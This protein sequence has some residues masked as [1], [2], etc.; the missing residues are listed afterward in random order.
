MNKKLVYTLLL[1]LTAMIW[2]AAF[3]AQSVSMELVEPFTFSA[4]RFAMGALALLPVIRVMDL[5]Q[6]RGKRALLPLR[7]DRELRRS[8]LV[9]GVIICAASN[10][11][12][13]G[14]QFTT[15]GKCGFI[16]TL[17]VAMVPV[18]SVLLLKRRYG[19]STWLGVGMAVVGMYFLCITESFAVTKGDVLVLL[20]AVLFAGHILAV[21]HYIA[22]VDGVRLAC[23]Q[24]LVNAL[25]SG[26]LMFL[27]EQPSLSAILAAWKPICYAGLLSCAV[28][29]TLQVVCQKEVEPT[30]A[31]LI[32][33]LESV[34]S[35][36]F[37]WLLL[38]EQLSRRE[39]L[40][41]VLTFCAVLIVELAPGIQRRKQ[42]TT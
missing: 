12:Q 27:F 14:I 33:S 34:F 39:L 36:L 26:V 19:P 11:Q 16:T 15:A 13:F 22:L 28:A 7:Q 2:G 30:L 1:F 20:C 6:G 8:G 18:L 32:M 4:V 10:F 3:V 5:K 37:G 42:L 21:D 24:M 9:C 31:S 25:L 29:Y 41:C 35:V 17:Y 23:L 38:H 40:G